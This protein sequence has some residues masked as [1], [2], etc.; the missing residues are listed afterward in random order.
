M[1]RG[2]EI[3]DLNDSS[4]SNNSVILWK[5]W[6]YFFFSPSYS[7]A[8]AVGGG[9]KCT[10]QGQQSSGMLQENGKKAVLCV[11][12]CDSAIS[13]NNGRAQRWLMNENNWVINTSEHLFRK[14]GSLQ[15]NSVRLTGYRQRSIIA[16]LKW[17]CNTLASPAAQ[18]NSQHFRYDN[19]WANTPVFTGLA[20]LKW[21]LVWQSQ[22][23]W[24]SLDSALLA[25]TVVLHIIWKVSWVGE[26]LRSPT[27]VSGI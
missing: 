20:G 10:L 25:S 2:V 15:M 6:F 23:V 22:I 8:W 13:Q 9:E 16:G 27:R 17:H 21:S 11:T 18:A 4:N 24:F 19:P 12:A 7:V 3:D 5:H 14:N 26:V 1:A